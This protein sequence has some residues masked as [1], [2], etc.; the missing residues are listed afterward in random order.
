M[1]F[2]THAHL[3]DNRFDGDREQIICSM[4]KS[5]VSY[6]T[7]IGFDIGSSKESIELAKQHPFIYATVGVHAHDVEALTEDDFAKIAI[8]A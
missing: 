8:L 6:I 7:N 5:G 3:N 2:D 1:L 4:Q